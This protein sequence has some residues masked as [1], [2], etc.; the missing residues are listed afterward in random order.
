MSVVDLS[1]VT[2]SVIGLLRDQLAQPV[3]DSM[4][5]VSEEVGD[6]LDPDVGFVVVNHV[7]GAGPD[8]GGYI[9]AEG[10]HQWLRY[11]VSC[12]GSTRDQAEVIGSL[13]ASVLTAKA[14]DTPYGY[15]HDLVVPGHT[16]LNRKFV[17]WI[18]SERLGTAQSGCLVALYVGIT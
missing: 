1:L 14:T 2:S 17:N 5:S 6:R 4:A 8:G 11:Q 18:P 10:A 15:I 7:V 9:G 13:A 16:V 12:S 3:G